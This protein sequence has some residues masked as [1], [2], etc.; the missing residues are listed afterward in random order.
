MP[1]NDPNLPG[2]VIRPRLRVLLNNGT[3]TQSA[4]EQ[5]LFATQNELASRH[6]D[7]SPVAAPGSEIPQPFAASVES[8]NNYQADRF[9]LSFVPTLSGVGSLD[10]WSRQTELPVDIQIGLAANGTNASPSWTS[11]LIGEAD[12][13]TIDP[14]RFL[15]DIEG[16]DL[17]ARMIDGKVS[18]S[19]VNQ[20]SAQ[21]IQSIAA[22]HGLTA[23]VGSTAGV[24][25]R[26]WATDRETSTFAQSSALTTD[27]D[28]IVALAKK[29]GFDAYVEGT[30]LHFKPAAGAGNNYIWRHEIDQQGRQI[31]NVIDLKMDRILT[32]SKGLHVT[33]KSWHAKQS[34]SFV[35]T[36]SSTTSIAPKG[37]AAAQE[38]I[39]QHP[40]MTEDEAQDYANRVASEIAKHELL[41]Q[42]TLP[43]DLLLNTRLMVELTGTNTAFDQTYFPSSI[44]KE[45]SVHSGFIM[46]ASCKNRADNAS[47]DR[48]VASRASALPPQPHRTSLNASGG[49][50]A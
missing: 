40:N 44:T 50:A 18:A 9:N 8:N 27:W 21:I 28:M 30:T 41:I 36:S 7:I 12:K 14:T 17:T 29:E 49:T 46:H 15:V 43:G 22:A 34:R 35:K 23:E 32:A 42:A 25:G 2:Y 33:V 20:S 24:S 38:Y 13:M 16:R 3:S 45:V 6:P 47:S 5:T 48:H 31:G 1:I 4:A 11:L 39:L 19:Y 26:F 10:W 37:T